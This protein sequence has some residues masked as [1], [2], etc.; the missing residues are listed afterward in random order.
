MGTP[1]KLR[2]DDCT[3]TPLSRREFGALT[4]SAM[5]APFAL[6]GRVRASAPIAATDVIDRIKKN[7][8]VEWKPET[9]DTIKAGDPAT[10]VSGVV[11]TAMAS[12]SVLRRAVDAGANLIITAEPTFYGRNDGRTPPAGRGGRGAPPT[13]PDRRRPRIRVHRQE[14]L[15]REARPRRLPVEPALA[16]SAAR[17]VRHRAGLRSR[18]EQAR[19]GDR[20]PL[21]IRLARFVERIGGELKKKLGSSRRDP[22]HRRSADAGADGRAPPWI[23]AH[24]RGAGQRFRPST[25][26]VAGEVRE[27]ES[28]EYARD[29]VCVRRSARA[30]CSSV[31]S[32]PR[33]AA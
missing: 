24:R 15:H 26:V 1:K 4:V 10:A 11:T 33:R 29:V 19:R 27:W 7:I 8:G 17:S 5:A 31:A 21:G 28:A 3:L 20:R 9:F 23:D 16:A 6:T 13:P 22:R 30:S 12:M 18:L 32:C 2:A 25:S 14:R